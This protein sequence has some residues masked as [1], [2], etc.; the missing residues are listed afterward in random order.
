[1][2]GSYGCD[3]I[4][5]PDRLLKPLVKRNN[6]LEE[7][8]WDEALEQ[9]ASGFKQVKDERG[10]DRLAVLGSSKCTNEENYLLQKFTRAV[11]GTNN[12]DHCA[13]L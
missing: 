12:V 11:L 3:F 1:V 7:V 9:V 6:T 13:R 4:H 2:R 8:S 5:S 10:S